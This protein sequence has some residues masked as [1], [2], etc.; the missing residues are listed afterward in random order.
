M[1]Q[2][3]QRRVRGASVEN[4]HFLEWLVQTRA[5]ILGLLA[6]YDNN[7]TVYVVREWADQNLSTLVSGGQCTEVETRALVLQLA[8]AIKRLHGMEVIHRNI[9]LESIIVIPHNEADGEPVRDVEVEGGAGRGDVETKSNTRHR[10]MSLKLTNFVFASQTDFETVVGNP[11]FMAPEMVRGEHYSDK[12]D[13]WALGVVTYTL[14]SG[15]QPFQGQ[16][17]PEQEIF[18]SDSTRKLEFPSNRWGLVDPCLVDFIKS[19]CTSDPSQR[20]T[21]DGVYKLPWL[22][23]ASANA[24]TD[25]ADS[26]AGGGGASTDS[27]AGGSG[28]SDDDERP[29]RLP[30]GFNSGLLS[31]SSSGNLIITDL[32]CLTPRSREKWRAHCVALVPFEGQAENQLS[33]NPGDK[34]YIVEYLEGNW[35]YGEKEDGSTGY[36][37]HTSDYVEVRKRVINLKTSSG[38]RIS[39][40][41]HILRTQ[42]DFFK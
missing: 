30:S 1:K 24:S 21:I 9:C 13:V 17:T 31:A 8:G 40:V 14:F 42:S 41:K 2:W 25:G 18:A 38:S 3:Y 34:I 22:A 20:P 28:G 37:P 27:G 36:F 39:E 6:I 33:F 15:H 4:F 23:G 16:G 35:W 5:E 7:E 32:E 10:K 29:F 11:G 12:V 26:G 19:C